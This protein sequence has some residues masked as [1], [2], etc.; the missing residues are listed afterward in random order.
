MLSAVYTRGPSAQPVGAISLHCTLE[1]NSK[2]GGTPDVQ[3]QLHNTE[4]IVDASLHACVR[5]RS[6]QKDKAL[7]FVPPDGP[8]ELAKFKLQSVK[9]LQRHIPLIVT[10]S[11]AVTDED[12]ESQTIEARITVSCSAPVEDVEI[13]FGVSNTAS[14]EST[15]VGGTRPGIASED[16]SALKGIFHFDARTGIARWTIGSLSVDQR[17]LELHATMRGDASAALSNCVSSKFTVGQKSLSGV[18][19]ASLEIVNDVGY[20][21]FKGVRSIVKGSVDW[22]W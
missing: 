1:G 7:H 10:C 19:L 5:L 13:L 11:K 9:A 4:R 3:L 8:F 17:P 21:P 6:W 2:L 20:K 18:K 15:L 14:L 12:D 22:R 16:L